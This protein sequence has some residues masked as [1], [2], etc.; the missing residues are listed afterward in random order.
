MNLRILALLLGL[1]LCGQL[2]AQ[3]ALP[4]W[5]TRFELSKGLETSGYGECLTYCR[6]LD[7]SSDLIEYRSFGT[8]SEGRELPLLLFG[9]NDAGFVEGWIV[10]V[11]RV[12]IM[13]RLRVSSFDLWLNFASIRQLGSDC[14]YGRIGIALPLQQSKRK[15]HHCR[16]VQQVMS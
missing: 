8:S 6:R 16:L 14:R 3:T 4:P 2:S 13:L 11:W 15:K 10:R 12:L 9:G 1:L 5:Q 7:G